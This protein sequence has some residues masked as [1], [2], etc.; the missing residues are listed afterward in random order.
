[1]ERSFQEHLREEPARNRS[2]GFNTKCFP[3]IDS[4]ILTMVSWQP[5]CLSMKVGLG[6]W[7]GVD[8]IATYLYYIRRKVYALLYAIFPASSPFP[9]G[10]VDTEVFAAA[11]EL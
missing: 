3:Y 4:F 5:L 10:C 2:V 8:L 1:M 11:A 6:S 7:L 9:D